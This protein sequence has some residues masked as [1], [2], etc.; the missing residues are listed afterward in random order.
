MVRFLLRETQPHLVLYASPVNFDPDAPVY[1]IS[2]P[3]TYA[4]ELAQAVGAFHTTGMVEDHGGLNNGRFDEA[5]YLAQCAGVMAE[6]ERMAAFEIGR[7]EGGLFFCLFD[8]PDRLQ[9]MFWRF[10]EPDHPANR[11]APVPAGFERA[12][13]D[14]YEACDAVVGRLLAG[15][16]PDALVVVMSDHGFGSFQ[17]GVHLNRWLLDEGLLAL[18]PGVDPG[19]AAGDLLTH[20]D[21][22]RTRAYALGL[23]SVYLNLAGREARGIV[24]PESASDLRHEIAARLTGLTDPGRGRVAVA[25]VSP[26]ETIY[27]GPYLEDAPDLL[28]RFGAGY[29]AS[30][31]TALG[32]VPAA[33]FEDNTRRWGGD[34]IVEPTLVPGVLLMNRPFQTTGARL[35]DLAP[36]ILD[37][38]GL[39][40]ETS[41]E[42]TSLLG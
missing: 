25:A 39:E 13:E 5:A 38:L 18:E 32:G 4:A 17:R 7:L 21:W 12:I 41:L 22:S 27:A 33:V 36:T 20:V 28:V 9:H 10:R 3:A 11:V 23:G 35:V 16:D 24:A 14:H 40:P 1:P 15:L 37:A 29:R 31:A 19:D 8:T 26:R 42:G 30:W 6:R 2:A 34:H